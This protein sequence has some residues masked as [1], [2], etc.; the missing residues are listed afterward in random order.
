MTQTNKTITVTITPGAKPD[1][2]PKVSPDP[3]EVWPNDEVEWNCSTDCEFTVVFLD[4]L[5]KPFKDRGFNKQK[6]KSGKPTQTPPPGEEEKYK[7]SV[8]VGGGV[9]DPDVIIRGR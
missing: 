1:D 5:K 7:Y 8:I 9:L 2:P 6:S 4:P 3:V